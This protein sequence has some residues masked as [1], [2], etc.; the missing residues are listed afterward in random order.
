MEGDVPQM[1]PELLLGPQVAD[2]EPPVFP[3]TE[4]LKGL[5]LG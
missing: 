2:S 4:E 3:H 1:L 5:W